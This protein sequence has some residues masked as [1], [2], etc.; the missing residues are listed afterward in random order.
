M[1][2]NESMEKYAILVKLVDDL[3]DDINKALI[4]GNK[5]AGVR[6]RKLIQEIKDAAQDLRVETLKINDDGNNQ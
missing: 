3:N 1:E 6:A 4:K 2:N 5:R